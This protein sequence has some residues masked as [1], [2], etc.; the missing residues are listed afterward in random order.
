M[1]TLNTFK[2][3]LKN[4][5]K[6]SNVKYLL[7]N[8]T[9]SQNDLYLFQK[10]FNDD[11]YYNNNYNKHLLYKN[12]LL[13]CYLIFWNKNAQSSIHDHSQNGCYYKILKGSL[14]EYVYNDK[15]EL[16][17]LNNLLNNEVSYIDNNIGYH[18]MINDNIFS[19][20]MHI[21]S[22]P[23]YIMNSY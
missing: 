9:I 21:Y 14:C 16:I 20:S 10:Q 23:D 8:S 3:N 15:L 19:V 1:N 5:T 22:P 12:D 18:K 11:S 4:I 6:F 13:D 7:H 17:R 2:N